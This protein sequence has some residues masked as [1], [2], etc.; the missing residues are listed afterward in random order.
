MRA[1][2]W[3]WG[4][5]MHASIDKTAEIQEIAWILKF[6]KV[7]F[8]AFR[9]EVDRV[10]QWRFLTFLLKHERQSKIAIA[11]LKEDE[12]FGKFI[13]KN[14]LDTGAYVFKESVVCEQLSHSR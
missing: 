4:G 14:P 12:E 8:D 7:F 9:I 1:G 10:A 11:D 2:V 6:S 3:D 13:K 5:T